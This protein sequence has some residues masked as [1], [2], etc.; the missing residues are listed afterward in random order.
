M[1]HQDDVLWVSGHAFFFFLLKGHSSAFGA[2]LSSKP[3][4]QGGIPEPW[5]MTSHCAD[6]T[7]ACCKQKARHPV[8]PPPLVVLA[9]LL[10]AL[11]LLTFQ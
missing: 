4:V 11:Q 6:H 2:E 5:S 8:P 3:G 1:N 7:A 10:Q 9:E